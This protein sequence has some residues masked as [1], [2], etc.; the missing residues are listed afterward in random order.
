MLGVIGCTSLSL[1]LLVLVT[2]ALKLRAVRTL[3]IL[4]LILTVLDL[5]SLL[6]YVPVFMVL[7]YS[8]FSGLPHGTCSS[9]TLAFY[10]SQAC[11]MLVNV[12][13]AFS[14]VLLS[15][16]QKQYIKWFTPRRTV[17]YVTGGC[18]LF[19]SAFTL[20]LVLL[21]ASRWRLEGDLETT[22]RHTGGHLVTHTGVIWPFVYF[23]PGYVAALC[24]L[25]VYMCIRSVRDGGGRYKRDCYEGGY[26]FC[27]ACLILTLCWLPYLAIKTFDPYQTRIPPY[28]HR[29]FLYLLLTNGLANPLT[30]T[31]RV[32]DFRKGVIGL[33]GIATSRKSTTD[34][35]YNEDWGDL[36]EEFRERE[37]ANRESYVSRIGSRISRTS[38]ASRSRPISR[39]PSRKRQHTSTAHDDQT[40]SA[41]KI[42]HTPLA[43]ITS[44]T[45]NTTVRTSVTDCL[46]SSTL[47]N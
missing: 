41:V 10:I 29:V 16:S 8:G 5:V 36:V 4:L 43:T 47:L 7:L 28:L 32:S 27:M 31:L 24:Y 11:S 19:A 35:L 37:R 34:T 20:C 14:R 18:F 23:L 12:V 13:L 9:A 46:M 38:R 30:Y 42:S 33:F 2:A 6:V 39:A 45:S 25:R 1:N 44:N 15:Q 21:S 26:T 17:L 3:H 40:P 22:C